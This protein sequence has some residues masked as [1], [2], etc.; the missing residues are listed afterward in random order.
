MSRQVFGCIVN[1]GRV[2]IA[3]HLYLPSDHLTDSN[4]V[5][6]FSW[7]RWVGIG[8]RSGI[9]RAGTE[10]GR[11]S[12]TVTLHEEGMFEDSSIWPEGYHYI[13]PGLPHKAV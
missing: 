10:A 12:Y 3:K 8:G 2:Y 6:T 1:S 5:E 9:G 4:S 13:I 11:S 7:G